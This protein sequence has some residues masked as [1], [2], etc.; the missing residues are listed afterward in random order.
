MTAEKRKSYL[1]LLIHAVIG[2]ACCAATMGIG[3]A[4]TTQEN[5]LIFHVVLAPLFFAGI[6]FNYFQ[7]YHHFSPFKTAA[8]TIFVVVL[9]DC[10]LVAL[11][12]NQSMEMFSSLIGSWIPFVLIFLS[13]Y[14]TGI[15]VGRLKG[16][17]V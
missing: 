14:V 8:I 13:S 12:I 17:S 5:A 11:V 2:W 3:M 9:I 10:F 6:S 1:I 15:L 16:R 7:K 4:V